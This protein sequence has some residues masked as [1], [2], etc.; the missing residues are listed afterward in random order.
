MYGQVTLVDFLPI[1]DKTGTKKT[2]VDAARLLF[3]C[4]LNREKHQTHET[5][6][7]G[8]YERVN[9]NG[10]WKDPGGRSFF[11]WAKAGGRGQSGRT[12]GIA[13]EVRTNHLRCPDPASTCCR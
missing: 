6:A 2:N 8:M 4:F 11:S 12:G 7:D 10:A 5:Y 3:D 9:A 1:K 13:Y